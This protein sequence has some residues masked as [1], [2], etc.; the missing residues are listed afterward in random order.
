[1]VN[2]CI[3]FKRRFDELKRVAETHGAK[4]VAQLQ[5]HVPFGMSC[6]LCVPYVEKM[7]KTGETE[8]KP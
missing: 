7:L 5:K 4:T 2:R 1:M 3:C 6:M 8:F